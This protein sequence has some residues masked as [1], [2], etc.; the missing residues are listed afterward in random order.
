MQSIYGPTVAKSMLQTEEDLDTKH[1]HKKRKIDHARRP[2]AYSLFSLILHCCLPVVFSNIF[3]AMRRERMAAN[4][5][6]S[7]NVE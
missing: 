5:H 4:E 6:D 2:F 3:N 1:R 7:K